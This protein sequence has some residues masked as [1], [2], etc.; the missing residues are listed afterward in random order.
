MLNSIQHFEYSLL[1]NNGKVQRG[2]NRA[3]VN[4][5]AKFITAHFT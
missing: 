5:H 2:L 3:N 4:N 1:F